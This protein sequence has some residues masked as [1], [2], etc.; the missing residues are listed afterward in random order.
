MSYSGRQMQH[1][2]TSVTLVNFRNLLHIDL[3]LPL[4]AVALAII[5]WFVMYSAARSTNILYFNRQILFFFIGIIA[6]VFFVSLDY[7]FFV[8]MAPLSYFGAVILLLAV[9]FFG[10]VVKGSERW[11]SLGSFRLQPSEFTKLVMVFTLTW[12]LTKIGDKIKKAHWFLL[13]FFIT[14]IPMGLILKQP[15][16]GTAASLGPLTLIMLY[17]AGCKKR[18]LAIIILLGLSLVPVLWWQMNNFDPKTPTQSRTFFE[19]KHYQKMRVYTYLNPEYDPRGS[20]WHT[21][22]SKITIGSGGLSGKGYMQGTQ[23]RLNYLPEHHTDF[24]Y[25][26]LAEEFGFVGAIAVIALFLILLLR[27]LLFAYDSSDMAG[28]LLATGV[29]TIFAFHIFV[30]IAITTG[31][32]PVTGIPLP[33]LSYGGSF[34]LTTMAGIGILLS[35]RLR[36]QAYLHLEGFSNTGHV[37][38]YEMRK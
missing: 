5:G 27:G 10:T 11:I 12:Y 3:W 23:T 36:R 14:A 21:L 30:N 9:M 8:S 1:K 6:L 17:I 25:S 26:L 2:N 19:L 18:H 16:L 7:R 33:F 28:T 35:V 22:Q 38:I 13:T 31:M 24:I 15:N 32:L 37:A 29:I 20:G 34:Y 4:I